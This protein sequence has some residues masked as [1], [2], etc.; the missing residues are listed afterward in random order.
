MVVGAAV[1]F[2]IRSSNAATSSNHMYNAY[3]FD[4]H[5]LYYQHACHDAVWYWRLRSIAHSAPASMVCFSYS[6]LFIIA[7]CALLLQPQAE[8][9]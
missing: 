8:Q 3:S 1:M 5:Y 7:V 6:V 9:R 4:G 2:I